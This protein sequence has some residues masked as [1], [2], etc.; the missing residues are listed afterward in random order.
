MGRASGPLLGRRLQLVERRTRRGPQ[1]PSG[2]TWLRG[3]LVLV[4]CR[5]S[6]CASSGG[7]P[8][9]QLPSEGEHPEDR[10]AEKQDA[11]AES[12][13]SSVRDGP[14]EG[15]AAEGQADGD[16]QGFADVEGEDAEY[17]VEQ[18]P[19]S[20]S[21]AGRSRCDGG[22]NSVGKD[23]VW[24]CRRCEESWSTRPRKVHRGGRGAAVNCPS[25]CPTCDVFAS[26]SVDRAAPSVS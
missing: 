19:G 18:H 26:L 17:Q 3:H 10:D 25:R 13:P 23:Y 1:L 5:R 14:V 15:A 4:G 22:H 9:S 20:G 8:R 2:S 21:G 7:P 11:E 6:F 12:G 16:D 24:A